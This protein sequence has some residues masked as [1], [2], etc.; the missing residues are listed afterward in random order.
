MGVTEI[1]GEL[2]ERS[3][4]PISIFWGNRRVSSISGFDTAINPISLTLL[5][6]FQITRDKET[7]LGFCSTNTE[8]YLRPD[9]RQ[10]ALKH[11][12]LNIVVFLFTICPNF[13][14]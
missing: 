6:L 9:E 8:F 2:P 14:P 10:I 12:H 3:C 5:I 4:L 7:V 11:S 1:E 13:S